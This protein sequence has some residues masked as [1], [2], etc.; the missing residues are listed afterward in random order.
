MVSTIKEYLRSL[1]LR[2][3][4]RHVKGHADLVRDHSALTWWELRNLEVDKRAQAYHVQLTACA[5]GPA[6]NPPFFPE[7]AALF[8]HDEKLSCLDKSYL[9][10]LVAV[11][12]W[13]SYWADK[14]RITSLN[15]EEIDWQVLG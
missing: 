2:I 6:C 7:P 12:D 3:V 4:P 14:G 1:P 15:L 13:S 9:L 8:V 5:A 10:D 11:E